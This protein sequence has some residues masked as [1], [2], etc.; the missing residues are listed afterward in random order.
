MATSLSSAA[1]ALKQG[2]GRLIRSRADRGVVAVL[3]RRLS[4]RG[5]GKVFLDSLPPASRL[6]NPARECG[7]SLV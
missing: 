6:C 5:Y 7:V 3:D 2:F 4:A 1:L